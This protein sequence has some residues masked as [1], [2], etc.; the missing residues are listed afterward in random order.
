[1]KFNILGAILVLL[2]IVLINAYMGTRLKEQFVG[3]E[4]A[5]GLVDRGIE[6]FVDLGLDALQ[7]GAKKMKK[8][9]NKKKVKNLLKNMKKNVKNKIIKS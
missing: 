7:E 2:L 6:K 3:R 8:T 5:E 4:M 9:K 1:M